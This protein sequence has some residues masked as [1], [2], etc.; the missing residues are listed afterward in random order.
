MA[1]KIAATPKDNG[2]DP[3]AVHLS[4]MAMREDAA[5]PKA[6]MG[7]TKAMREAG[8]VYLPKMRQEDGVTYANR[9]RITTLRNFYRQAILSLAGKLM[10]NGL[11]LDSSSAHKGP[12]EMAD[13]MLDMDNQG[14][15]GDVLFKRAFTWAVR[16]SAMWLIAD[17]PPTIAPDGS[18]P[19]LADE[20]ALAIRPYLSPVSVWDALGWR[21]ARHSGRL[22]TEQFRYMM[23]TEEPVGLFGTRPVK[24][25]RCIEPT[26]IRDFRENSKGEWALHQEYV[27]TLGRVPVHRLCSD[28]DENHITPRGGMNDL[29]D[30]NLE[31]WQVRSDQR[32][33]LRINSFPI[34]FGSGMEGELPA[35]GPEQAVLASEPQAKL[36]YVESTGAALTAGRQEL[37]DLEDAMRAMSAQYQARTVAQ[38]ATASMIDAKDANAPAQ[39]WALNVKRGFEAAMDDMAELAGKGKGPGAGG[40]LSVDVDALVSSMDSQQLTLLMQAR[41]AREI[42]RETFLNALK[43]ADLLPDEFDADH[44]QDLLDSEP[45]DDLPGMNTPPGGTKP[46]KKAE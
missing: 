37:V 23:V 28:R 17:Y 44:D 30:L 11:K 33:T 2:D 18:R 22:V 1:K 40:S 5:L 24:T 38:T 43:K 42:S 29:A 3:S 46:K 32:L 16:D 45:V 20:R 6:L 19:T 27:N 8:E 13:W 12:A 34:L 10:R 39:G 25:I 26:T 21:Q 9:L 31:H 4:I 35:L 41:T 14:T 7:G 15:P 36:A